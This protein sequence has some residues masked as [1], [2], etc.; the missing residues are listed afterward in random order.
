LFAFHQDS[1]LLSG[2]LATDDYL[3]E[4][5]HCANILCSF[6]HI[7]ELTLTFVQAVVGDGITSNNQNG[8]S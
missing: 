7:W 1:E 8:G 3:E 4:R 5:N 6:L 2:G